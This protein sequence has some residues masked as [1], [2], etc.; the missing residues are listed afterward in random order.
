[1]PVIRIEFEFKS[2]THHQRLIGGVLRHLSLGGRG[3]AMPAEDLNF[4]LSL[5]THQTARAP[6]SLAA[7]QL[8]LH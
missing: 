5:T 3:L 6:E 4:E 1:M 2:V 8:S 7:W